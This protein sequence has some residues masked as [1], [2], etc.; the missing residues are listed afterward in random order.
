[1]KQLRRPTEGPLRA[2]G[3]TRVS[4]GQQVESGLGMDAQRA[5]IEGEAAHRGW[6]LLRWLDNPDAP[7]VTTRVVPLGDVAP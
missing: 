5:V 1:M 2:I 4:T 3:Y 7:P 6:V